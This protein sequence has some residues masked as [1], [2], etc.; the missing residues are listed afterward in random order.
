MS[1]NVYFLKSGR[2]DALSGEEP[3]DANEEAIVAGLKIIYPDSP[4]GISRVV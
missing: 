4:M 1:N 2:S 3:K